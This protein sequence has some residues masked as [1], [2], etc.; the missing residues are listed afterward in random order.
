MSAT[1]LNLMFVLIVLGLT[2]AFAA[3]LLIPG[4]RSLDHARGDLLE[5][6]NK[7]RAAQNACGDEAELLVA[8]EKLD[9]ALLKSR[10]RVP[11]ERYFG[12]FLN[13]LAE[14]ARDLGVRDIDLRP[15]PEHPL[16]LVPE[17]AAKSAGT[18]TTFVLPVRIKMVCPFQTAHEFLSRRGQMRRLNRVAAIRIDALDVRPPRVEMSVLLETYYYP[19]QDGVAASQPAGGLP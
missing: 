19:E 18:A 12:E 17:G 15:L 2:G 11:T 5:A 1:R 3:G 9:Q 7:A 10:E 8:I 16:R 13:D 14:L 6:T 4:L